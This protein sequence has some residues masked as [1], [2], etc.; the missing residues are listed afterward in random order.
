[1]ENFE[2]NNNLDQQANKK[3][4]KVIIAAASA[5]GLATALYVA[6]TI[7]PASY[8]K[9]YTCKNAHKFRN[10]PFLGKTCTKC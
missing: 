4:K 9:D 6:F 10:L 8:C 5:I 1:M 7:S 3:K 2:K